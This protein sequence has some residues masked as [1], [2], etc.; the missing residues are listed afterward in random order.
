MSGA[1]AAILA[2]PL[3]NFLAAASSLPNDQQSTTNK[4]PVRYKIII[5]LLILNSIIIL[6]LI[7]LIY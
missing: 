6:F 2:P 5:F 1:Q 7:N 3:T 4:Y